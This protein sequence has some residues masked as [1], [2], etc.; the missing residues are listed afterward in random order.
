MSTEVGKLLN[1]AVSDT[2]TWNPPKNEIWAAMV[3]NR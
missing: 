3:W 1:S 2:P